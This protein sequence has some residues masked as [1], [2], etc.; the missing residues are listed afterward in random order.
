MLWREYHFSNQSHVNNAW[1][2]T[3]PVGGF[4]VRYC[5]IALFKVLPIFIYKHKSSDKPPPNIYC[6]MFNLSFYFSKHTPYICN[7]KFIKTL[8]VTLKCCHGNTWFALIIKFCV[9]KQKSES[10]INRRVPKE[11]K[12]DWSVHTVDYSVYCTTFL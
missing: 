11:I 5:Y 10:F 12:Q 4:T 9:W 3:C 2:P 7:K 8:L 1:R 6:N